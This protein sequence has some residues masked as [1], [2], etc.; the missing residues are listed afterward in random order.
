MQFQT[1]LVVQGAKKFKD[2][3]DGT[4]FDMTTL[5]IQ[6]TLD[7][8]KGNAK[9]F[10]AQTMQWGTSEEFDKIKHL[11]FPFEADATVELVT[12]G[13]QQKQRI[14]NLKPVQ[15]ASKPN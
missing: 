5:F 14:L 6:M 13:K 10:A 1:R 3:I 4:P 11:A 2:S 9:G 15:L 12:S 7:D 8:S